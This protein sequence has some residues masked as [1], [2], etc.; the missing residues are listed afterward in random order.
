MKLGMEAHHHLSDSFL[1]GPSCS[2]REDRATFSERARSSSHPVVY[3]PGPVKLDRLLDFLEPHDIPEPLVPRKP[4]HRPPLPSCC[5]EPASG[6]HW[7]PRG[8][9]PVLPH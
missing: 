8:R 9:C 3:G 4:P 7:K 1:P 6:N 5:H 2:A